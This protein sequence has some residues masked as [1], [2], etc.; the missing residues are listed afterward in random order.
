ML[1]KVSSRCA[2]ESSSLY[3]FLSKPICPVYWI[4][5]S[6]SSVPSSSKRN[7]PVRFSRDFSG[8]EIGVV[9]QKGSFGSAT[10]ASSASS[11]QPSIPKSVYISAGLKNS[12]LSPT[13]T[14]INDEPRK[15]ELARAFL[16]KRSS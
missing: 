15:Y 4:C 12:H 2:G 1:R 6:P 5:T 11:R 8:P 13:L 16:K 7:L 10:S 9:T 3:S 14:A